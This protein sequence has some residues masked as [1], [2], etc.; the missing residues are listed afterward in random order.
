MVGGGR[1]S[2]TGQLVG[3][4]AGLQ[5]RAHHLQGLS[6]LVQ[7]GVQELVVEA[8]SSLIVHTSLQHE[9]MVAEALV[10]IAPVVGALH[11]E[12]H[13]M[14]LTGAQAPQLLAGIRPLQVGLDREGPILV[15]DGGHMDLL[16]VPDRGP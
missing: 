6:M 12:A 1:E 3:I 13:R 10:L 11:D 7:P 2:N 5:L 16:V 15:L 8:S 9:E 14:E 4:I